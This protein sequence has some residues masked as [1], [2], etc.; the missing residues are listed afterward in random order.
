MVSIVILSH[1]ASHSLPLVSLYQLIRTLYIFYYKSLIHNMTNYIVVADLLRRQ[2]QRPSIRFDSIPVHCTLSHHSEDSHVGFYTLCNECRQADVGHPVSEKHRKA[3]SKALNGAVLFAKLLNGKMTLS[4]GED[5][6]ATVC[7][8]QEPPFVT[9][10]DIVIVADE[11]FTGT[12]IDIHSWN[13]FFSIRF[14]YSGNESRDAHTS[15]QYLQISSP[16]LKLSD[17]FSATQDPLL[18]DHIDIVSGVCIFNGDFMKDDIS[19]SRNGLGLNHVESLKPTFHEV[20][21]IARSSPAI[22]DIA[23]MLIC[24]AQNGKSRPHVTIN[25]DVPSFHYYHTAV[26]QYE[27]GTCT[28]TEA[29]QWMNA[30]DLRHDQI[31]EVFTK[32]IQHEIQR[33]G[34]YFD[35]YEIRVS[36]RNNFLA[37]AIRKGLH[38]GTVSSLES[39]LEE[40]NSE[41][42]ELWQEFYKF[43]PMQQRPQTFK[44][45]GFLFYV[46]EVVKSAL[47]VVSTESQ[48]PI[49]LKCTPKAGVKKPSRLIISVDDPAE[50]RIY[51]QS[52][53][54]LRKIRSSRRFSDTALVEAYVCRRIF[55]DGNRSRAR[56]YHQDPMPELPSLQISSTREHS[57]VQLVEPLDAVCRL[58]GDMSSRNLHSWFQSV[59]IKV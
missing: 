50:R 53:E 31:G 33:R 22:A 36:P 51:S 42:N 45:L 38:K 55:V 12:Q 15:T 41:K 54:A 1:L 13:L 16:T 17:V 21:F 58:H 34:I 7:L 52:Q 43:V 39:T 8:D 3:V 28:A 29:L 26:K 25:L 46:F 9:T 47:S 40:L 30:V 37:R 5:S 44:D 48:Q 6:Q 20:D 14:H 57:T 23:A 49:S 27:E 19:N 18:F 2:G 32:A 35:G 59:G 11:T 4:H 56:L 10:G 24:R